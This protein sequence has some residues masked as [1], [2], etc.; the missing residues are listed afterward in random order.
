MLREAKRYPHNVMLLVFV[1]NGSLSKSSVSMYQNSLLIV[2]VGTVTATWSHTLNEL[3]LY[4]FR[5]LSKAGTYSHLLYLSYNVLRGM[6]ML[7]R[8]EILSKS[9]CSA[10]D[11]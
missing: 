10:I 9:L 4:H 1:R 5:L 2:P 7:A 11:V 8:E 3:Q 6:G